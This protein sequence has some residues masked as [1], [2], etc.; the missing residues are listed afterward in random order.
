MPAAV[1]MAAEGVQLTKNSLGSFG[2]GAAVDLDLAVLGACAER[3]K[4]FDGSRLQNSESRVQALKADPQHFFR[5]PQL[6][7]GL[8][9]PAYIEP[10]PA[11]RSVPRSNRGECS[12][13]GR[14][15]VAKHMCGRPPM[16]VHRDN[17]KTSVRGAGVSSGLG[18][19]GKSIS[20]YVLVLADAT[21]PFLVLRTIASPASHV[22]SEQW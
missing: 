13:S 4:V 21:P 5:A 14:N 9:G 22:W 19:P 17:A 1:R 11:P 16:G 10:E 15:S 8:H 2:R 6:L 18:G 12:L 7:P 3:A 20:R